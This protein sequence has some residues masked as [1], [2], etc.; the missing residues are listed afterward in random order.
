MKHLYVDFKRINC[1][2]KKKKNKD[3]FIKIKPKN[4]EMLHF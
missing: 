4:D 1:F 2:I 3:I